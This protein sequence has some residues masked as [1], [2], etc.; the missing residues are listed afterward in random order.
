M[1]LSSDADLNQTVGKRTGDTGGSV[2]EKVVVFLN[3][4]LGARYD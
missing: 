3:H 1:T 2:K 4:K